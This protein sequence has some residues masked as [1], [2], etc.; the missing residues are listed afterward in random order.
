MSHRPSFLRL[1]SSLDCSRC[2]TVS[3]GTEMP[4]RWY[5]SD[6]ACAR[7]WNEVWTR[8]KAMALRTVAST[9]SVRV[10]PCLRTDSSSARNSGSTRI[11]GMTADFIDE[12]YCVCVTAAMGP[13]GAPARQDGRSRLSATSGWLPGTLLPG[14]T[15]RHK[16]QPGTAAHAWRGASRG[17]PT[18][19]TPRSSPAPAPMR[20]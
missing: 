5:S 11:W 2:R 13:V 1:A 3:T 20:Q 7:A 10:S 17:G 16:R 6:A 9:K 14:S 19:M 18:L 12:V 15:T 8:L 4:V